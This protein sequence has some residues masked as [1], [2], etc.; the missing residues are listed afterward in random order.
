MKLTFR[1]LIFASLIGL[2][3]GPLLAVPEALTHH[4]RI[5]V[6][7]VNYTGTGQ[8]RF[9]LVNAAGDTT[10]WSNDGTSSDGQQPADAVAID[11]SNGFYR[12]VLGD[13]AVAN[14]TAI[15]KD[16]FETDDV[17]LRVW[18]DD[19]SNGIQQLSPDQPFTSV[20]YAMKAGS[21][22]AGAITSEMIA[23]GAI[24]ADKLDPEV[25]EISIT[26]EDLPSDL[27]AESV[28]SPLVK[29]EALE[30]EAAT[31]ASLHV[32]GQSGEPRAP[33][34]VEAAVR[35]GSSPENHV[36]F[37]KNAN[38]G[39]NTNGIAVMLENDRNGAV[40]HSNNFMTFYN[41][42]D[43]IAGRIEGMSDSDLELVMRLVKELEETFLTSLGLFEFHLE[44]EQNEDWFD[45]GALPTV[46]LEG[47]E[48]PS[49]T[50]DDG[51]LPSIAF[52]PGRLPQPEFDAGRLPS[53]TFEDGA[54][55]SLSFSRGE[56]PDIDFSRGRLP[57]LSFNPAPTLDPGRLPSMT[58][59]PGELPQV[60][61]N[62]GQLPSVNFNRGQLPSLSLE[63]GRLPTLDFNPGT[64]PK[65]SLDPGEL[66]TVIAEGG[67]LPAIND[68]PIELRDL[69]IRL[70]QDRLNALLK[71]FGNDLDLLKKAWRL[72]HD[73]V[74]AAMIRSQ[75]AF[76]GS[77]V[78]YESGSG[79]YAEWLERMDPAQEMH[80]GD[81]VGVFGGKISTTTK[82]ADQVLVISY[83]PIV[84]GN[85][86]ER[87][88]DLYEKVA[89]MGQVPV[90]VVGPVKKGDYIVPTGAE[91]GSGKAVS[92][93]TITAEQLNKVVGVS[94]AD[95]DESGLKYVKIIVG[96]GTNA[97]AKVFADQ[98]SQI[99]QLEADVA[100]MK[101]QTKRVAALEAQL[102]KVMALVGAQ[103]EAVVPVST[104]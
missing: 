44:I 69:S 21:V 64:L 32:G 54:L 79:D 38:N 9:A 99:A 36:M 12:I 60:T 88:H 103:P 35:A 46:R 84:L 11:V 51:R 19:R 49:I 89:F 100:A 28:E 86:P 96:L 80:A 27:T 8:F 70:N 16:V 6:D 1:S 24:S 98:S 33:L 92:P 22:E 56:L 42:E 62:R 43:Q 67:R 81:I 50:F 14:M 83:R 90:K 4:G 58:V 77:G 66:P 91:D 76:E 104:H 3:A 94:W 26:N 78:T 48:L 40:N 82:G 57:G 75:I 23:D 52:T 74:C 71:E 25:L 65:V 5:T 97:Y 17:H 47:G 13:E 45:P 63:G 20:G 87:D 95:S 72:F 93:D 2:T 10:Y 53:L 73:P 102:A 34:H 101:A 61:F 37:V 7:Q 15:P 29:A 31:T 59:D 85:M 39:P 41:G 18:F 30:A 68:L 55:P